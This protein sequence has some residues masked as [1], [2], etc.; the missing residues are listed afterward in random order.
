[1]CWNA[2]ISLIFA[3]TMGM[4]AITLKY[5]GYSMWKRSAYIL[6]LYGIMQFIQ[7]LNWLTILPLPHGIPF[8]S[9]PD[10]NKDNHG[11]Q[12]T[13]VNRYI[14]YLA[15]AN[16]IIQ[17]LFNTLAVAAGESK[18]RQ[19]LFS[20]P[21]WASIIFFIS[22]IFQ[23]YIG[24][25]LKTPYTAR[26]SS[27]MLLLPKM[28]DGTDSTAMTYAS[29]TC[30]YIGPGGYILWRFKLL[31]TS[32]TPT[33]FIYHL[34][35]IIMFYISSWRQ[36]FIFFFG[37]YV[38]MSFA[39]WSYPNS[40]ESAAYWCTSTILLPVLLVVDAA[41]EKLLLVK[42]EIKDIKKDK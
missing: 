3:C 15:F 37:N 27:T 14:T 26:Q 31:H 30:T 24:E 32:F 17:P 40:G 11:A 33:Y 20:F 1:M 8:D 28:P 25:N 4:T 10:S 38:L 41:V 35:G 13:D 23:L 9:D 39:S 36:F 5:I 34:F 7:F 12:C 2:T 18:D 22:S 6:S 19:Q 29:T 42:N 21:L 16:I